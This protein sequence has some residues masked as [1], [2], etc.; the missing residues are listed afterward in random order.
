MHVTNLPIVV[1]SPTMITSPPMTPATPT[2]MNK[3]FSSTTT[4]QQPLDIFS[5][6][7]ALA[8]VPTSP[9]AAYSGGIL[10]PSSPLTP[11]SIMSPTAFSQSTPSPKPQ[12]QIKQATTTNQ[13][14]D[15]DPYAALRD[16]SIGSTKKTATPQ[17]SSSNAT[18]P[19][20]DT[21]NALKIKTSSQ[22][23]MSWGGKL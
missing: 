23:S 6:L 2:M 3:P 20:S 15:L 10:Q 18:R 7:A 1:V 11:S 4:T 22:D 14:A 16:L 19:T 13:F 9:T 17:P 21:L 12:V 5:E 8:P